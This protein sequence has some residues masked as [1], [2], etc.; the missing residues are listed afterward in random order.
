LTTQEL[1]AG[2]RRGDALSGE[3]LVDLQAI[4]EAGDLAKFAGADESAFVPAEGTE[5][6]LDRAIRFV[7]QTSPAVRIA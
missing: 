4:L 2:L 3:P 1:L 7:E 6:L 5:Q